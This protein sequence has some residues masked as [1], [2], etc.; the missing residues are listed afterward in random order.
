MIE[1]DL[2][3]PPLK[4]QLAAHEHSKLGQAKWFEAY[5]E[6]FKKYMLSKLDAHQGSLAT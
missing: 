4:E 3:D 5:G 1:I 6:I 2:Y